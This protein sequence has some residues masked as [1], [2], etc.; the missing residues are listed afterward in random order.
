MTWACKTIELDVGRVSRTVSA[1]E[2][3]PRNYLI[4]PITYV[5]ILK[6]LSRN[7]LLRSSR[8]QR[9]LYSIMIPII[10]EHDR[11]LCAEFISISKLKALNQ[12]LIKGVFIIDN[13]SYIN[14]LRILNDVHG[15]YLS[16]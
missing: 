7:L 1:R 3:Q 10:A 16:T 14:S 8:A 6:L 11:F 4:L 9:L 2:M 13:N 12:I 5:K 15:C